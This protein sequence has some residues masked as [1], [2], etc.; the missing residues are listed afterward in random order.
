MCMGNIPRARLEPELTTKVRASSKAREV[1]L[2]GVW[3]T[4]AVP[5]EVECQAVP[6]CRDVCA[7]VC[8]PVSV[9]I[10]VYGCIY[11]SVYVYGCA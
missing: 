11:V 3:G 5:M 4:T 7:C 10:Y 1:I 2:S 6:S 8:M 9:W